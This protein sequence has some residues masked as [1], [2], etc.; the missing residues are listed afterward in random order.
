MTDYTTPAT[1]VATRFHRDTEW[2]VASVDRG[3]HRTVVHANS[4]RAVE[5]LHRLTAHLDAIVDVLIAYPREGIAWVGAMRFLPDVRE[6][7]GRLRW[8]LAAHG[9]AEITI[10]TP[11]EQISL[12]PTLDLVIYARRDVWPARLRAEGITVRE[13][14]PPAV[15]RAPANPPAAPELRDALDAAAARLDLERAE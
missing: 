9:G 11:D 1:D 7:I 6:T 12:M 3:Y 2:Y 10:A 13:S 15:W 14:A 5:L 4:E 8:P